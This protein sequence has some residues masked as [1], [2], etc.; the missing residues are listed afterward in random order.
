MAHTSTTLD[1][2]TYVAELQRADEARL[3]ARIEQAAADGD[4]AA[5]AEPAVLAGLVQTLWQGL[6]VRAELGADR[7]ELLEVVRLAVASIDP[8][9]RDADRR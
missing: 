2:R 9:R 5:V 1:V 7:E 3:R 4:P 8:T 6:S